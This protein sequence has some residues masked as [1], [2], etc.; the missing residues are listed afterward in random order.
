MISIALMQ[1]GEA[2]TDYIRR[3]DAIKAIQE[4]PCRSA[5]QTVRF[6]QRIRD[7][8]PSA[9]VV[10]VIRCKDCKWWQKQQ[11]G[12]H[13]ICNRFRFWSTGMFYCA[14]SEAGDLDE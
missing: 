6:V 12:I 3:Q 7:D 10:E 2:M 13:G 4:T 5:T 11:D 14:A 8:V 9:D 1:K